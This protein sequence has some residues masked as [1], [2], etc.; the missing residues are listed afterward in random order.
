MGTGGVGEATGSLGDVAT[1]LAEGT[2][3][4]GRTYGLEGGIALCIH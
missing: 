2:K 3:I 1:V 4:L